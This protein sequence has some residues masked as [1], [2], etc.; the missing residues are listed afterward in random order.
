MTKPSALVIALALLVAL[1]AAAGP[2]QRR[3]AGFHGGAAV[4]TRSQAAGREIWYQATAGNARFFA[5]VF[6]QRVGVFV[7]WY[8]VLRTDGREDRFAAYGLINDPGCCTPGA[9]GCPARSIDETYGLDWCP[10][11]ETLLK[12]VGRTGYRDPACDFRDG[13]AGAIN[14]GADQRQS[15]CDLQFGTSTGALGFRKFPNPRFDRKRWIQLNGRAGSWDGYRGPLSTD[16][17]S[18]D[19][20]R[21][22]LADASIEP[23]FLIGT[24]CG[25]CHIGFDPLNPPRDPAR[26]RWENINGTVGNQ[27]LRMS[28]L[29][30]SGMPHD[31]IEYQ[32]FL[33]ARPGVLDTSAIANDEIAN[34]GSINAIINLAQR[35]TFPAEVVKWRPV[36]ACAAGEAGGAQCWCEPGRSGKCW[37]RERRAERVHHILKGGED[38]I[39]LPEAIQRVYFNIGSCSEQCWVNHLPDPAQLDA[40]KRNFGQTPFNIGQCRR[41][42]PNFRAIEDRLGEIRDFLLSK[43]AHATDLQ[44]ARE[45]ARRLSRPHATYGYEDLVADL[46][47]QFGSGALARGRQLFAELCAGCHSSRPEASAGA[48]QAR[49]FRAVDAKTGMRRDWLGNDEPTK[50]SE[51]GTQPCR[52]LHSNHPAGQVWQE[53]GSESLR[54]RSAGGLGDGRGFYRNV[55]LLSA[56]AHAP[57]MHNNAIGPEICGKPGNPEN[58]FYRP[59]YV[60]RESRRPLSDE[61]APPCWPY[62]PSV[63]GRYR[64][65]VAS[66]QE[67][68][69]PA[70]RVAKMA[71]FEADVPLHMAG[72]TFTVPKGT[73]TA[74]LVNFRSKVLVGDLVE[75]RVRPDVL[76]TRLRKMFGEQDAKRHVDELRAVGDELLKRS[77]NPVEA[78]RLRPG[79]LQRYGTCNVDIEND[80]HTF[81]QDLSERDKNAL[82]AFVATL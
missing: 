32:A 68:L 1:N 49:D 73:S 56:W 61:R 57:F 30:G 33:R 28:E 21:R 63:E 46:E 78:I 9:P 72:A 53:F 66:M 13:V 6:P 58:F 2:A 74:S 45:N 81:G 34:P 47:R 12:F 75:L 51:I 77:G 23:P 42:C 7:D 25:S 31:S 76:E 29:L 35:P 69:N 37:L 71:Y 55:S 4:L 79:L 67:L 65:Y 70:K 10:G 38:S 3:D 15:P 40:R 59:P 62:D 64:L 24:S 18:P 14:D 8:R 39:G 80:G 11:D 50:A 27:Y 22:R 44:L 48:F 5:Y 43:E 60:D 17:S 41:D 52:A 19:A 36:N 54:A 20:R 82:I 26:P 16:T